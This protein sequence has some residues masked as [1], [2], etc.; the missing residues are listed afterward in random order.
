MANARKRQNLIGRHARPMG[1]RRVVCWPS[2]L[3][4][5][6]LKREA[7]TRGVVPEMLLAKVI[8]ILGNDDLYGAI[9]E[10]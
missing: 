1:C 9:L 3:A 8:E 5:E 6:R 7:K 10:Q 2:K 4:V